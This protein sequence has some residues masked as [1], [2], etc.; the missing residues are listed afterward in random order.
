MLLEWYARADRCRVCRITFEDVVH[1]GTRPV[2]TSLRNAMMSADVPS[3]LPVHASRPR[4]RWPVD[5]YLT[6]RLGRSVCM[7]RSISSSSS[8]SSSRSTLTLICTQV[9]A[10]PKS[11][12][13]AARSG[14]QVHGTR[15]IGQLGYVAHL[16]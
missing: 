14:I 2:E 3:Q 8:W 7:S 1:G 13:E 10:P 5:L 16:G 15:S 9:R 12:R 11:L 4:Y 6:A